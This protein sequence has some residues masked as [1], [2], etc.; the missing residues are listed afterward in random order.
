M[1]ILYNREFAEFNK[2]IFEENPKD[3]DKL[4]TNLKRARKTKTFFGNILIQNKEKRILIVAHGNVIRCMIGT[5]LGFPIRKT[6]DLNMFNCS[7]STLF[8]DKKN[9]VGIYHINSIDHY[10]LTK[11]TQKFNLNRLS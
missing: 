9:V 4:K 2:I 1:W 3:M 7:I 6:P 8:F 10:K 5:S 11:F